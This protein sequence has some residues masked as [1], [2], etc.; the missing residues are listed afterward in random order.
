M[1][2]DYWSARRYSDPLINRFIRLLR[3]S[4]INKIDPQTGDEK[5]FHK[6]SHILNINYSNL[7]I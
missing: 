4:E 7:T 2:A 3:V 6:S 1:N 5:G